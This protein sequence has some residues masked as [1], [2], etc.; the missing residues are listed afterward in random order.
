MKTTLGSLNSIQLQYNITNWNCEL[1]FLPQYKLWRL[2]IVTYPPI[3]L[4]VELKGIYNHDVKRLQLSTSLLLANIVKVEC[5]LN[6][7]LS[8]KIGLSGNMGLDMFYGMTNLTV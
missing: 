4:N 1:S 3:S 2:D 7:S 6:V 5:P 8:P